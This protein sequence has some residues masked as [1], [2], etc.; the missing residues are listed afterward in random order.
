MKAIS[1]NQLAFG[2]L[3]RRRRQYLTLALGIFLA[4]YFAATMLLFGASLP[5]TLQMMHN[6]NKGYQDYVFFNIG[7]APL[8][9]LA[10]AGL[11]AEYGVTEILAEVEPRAN[12]LFS[13]FSLA[14]FDQKALEL[15]GKRLI[16]GRLPERAGEIALE[17][18]ALSLQRI[19]AKPGE[20]VS[21]KLNIPNGKD[22]LAETVTKAYLLTGIL[23]DQRLHLLNEVYDSHFAYRD[24]PAGI[25]SDAEVIEAGGKAI[26]TAYIKLAPGIGLLDARIE[27]FAAKHSIRLQSTRFN[28]WAELFS[29][30]LETGD[31]I[32]SLGFAVFI[33]L[34]LL[35]AACLG[36]VNAFSG[37]LQQRKQQIGLLR[38][39][40]ATKRQI[41][42]IFGREAL[43]LSVV[44]IPPALALGC[45]TVWGMTRLLGPSYHFYPQPGVLAM[46][47]VAG[48]GG[49]WLASRIPLR[50][51]AQ[52]PPMQAIRDADL[53]RRMKT[54]KIRSR[55]QFQMSRLLASR[56]MSLYRN[57]LAGIT[58]FIILSLLLIMVIPF[59]ME[60]Q[61]RQ[62][63]GILPG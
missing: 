23:A 14:R 50:R 6:E 15:A 22:Y 46:V 38:A 30:N 55:K 5:Q 41:R 35:L 21:L 12:T 9:E 31:V 25:L 43:L 8:A 1:I 36:I 3:R 20:M 59:Y 52:I 56:N 34:V 17:Q 51:A 48:A 19:T 4:V 32:S 58:I 44:T 2:N 11:V 63:L 60:G 49:V 37:N 24:Y 29:G 39:V 54:R 28:G 45:L 40:G 18:E 62:M 16:A 26:R 10:D 57:N 7:D 61:L 42:Q 13:A 33:A 27:E 53:S 47:A